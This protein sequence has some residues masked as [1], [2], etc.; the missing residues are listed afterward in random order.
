MKIKFII[1]VLTFKF[2]EN[3]TSCC[4]SNLPPPALGYHGDALYIIV[5][6]SLAMCG[7][8]RTYKQDYH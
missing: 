4:P 3:P 8:A 6:P 7:D 5:V 1:I 2:T